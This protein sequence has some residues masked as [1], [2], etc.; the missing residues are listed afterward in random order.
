MWNLLGLAWDLYGL[1]FECKLFHKMTT[2]EF[3]RM[4]DGENKK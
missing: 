1:Y 2:G 4:W 3:Q